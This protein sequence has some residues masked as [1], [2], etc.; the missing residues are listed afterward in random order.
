MK[1]LLIYINPRG[2][3]DEEGK[4]LIKIQIDNSYSLGWK[5][6]DIMLFTNFPYE[7]NGIKANIIDGSSYSDIS[8]KTVTISHLF[9]LNIIQDELYWVHD[10]DAFQNNIITESEL[11]LDNIDFAITDY[12]RL[13]RWSGGSIFFKKSSKDIFKMIKE[14]VYEMN[15]TEEKALKK[16]TDWNINNVNPR[17]K[18]LNISYNFQMGNVNN[19][20]PV[21]VK[22]IKVLHFHPFRDWKGRNTLD[23][24]LRGK[25]KINTMLMEDRL[26][27][28]FNKYSIV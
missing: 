16:I 15:T 1:N 25:N 22:P 5:P 3:F 17:I 26:V 27:K 6:D 14:K 4:V 10:L 7:Y 23:F 21:A 2:D 8:S 9:D 24:F 20:Y 11:E 12:G 19:C 28:I 18:K 13:L